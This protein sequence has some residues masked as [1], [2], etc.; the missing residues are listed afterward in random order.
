[1]CVLR[2]KYDTY[3]TEY[4]V[5]YGVL[6]IHMYMYVYVPSFTRWFAVIAAERIYTF[7]KVQRMCS[8]TVDQTKKQKQI[9]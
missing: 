5:P 9:K 1:M 2:N 7:L 4:S 3:K 8:A 6:Y